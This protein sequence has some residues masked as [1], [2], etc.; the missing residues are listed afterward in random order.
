LRILLPVH[1]ID[2]GGIGTV[3]R[4]LLEHLPAALE[5]DEELVTLRRS[6]HGSPRVP[7]ANSLSRL[8]HEQVAVARAAQH[9][10][11]VHLPDHRPLLVS[12]TPFLLTVHDLFYVD[13]PDWLPRHVARY[14]RLMLRVALAKPPALVVCDSEY[15]RE[16]FCERF[17]EVAERVRVIRPGV[18]PRPPLNGAERGKPYFLTVST[19]EP[20]KNH[21]GLLRAFRLARERGLGLRWKVAGAAGYAAGP[22]LRALRAQEGVDV[23]G[24]VPPQQLERLFASARFLA[25]P[26]LGEGFGFPPLEAMA[27]GL[28]VICSSGTALDETVGAAALRVSP[29]DQIAWSD[30]LLELAG[31]DAGRARLAALGAARATR[32]SW[33]ASARAYARAYREVV[34][35]R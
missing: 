12:R 31:D 21:L 19:I 3:V 4:G 33:T 15:V 16:R 18:E 27:R 26:A 9:A 5:D 8:L 6:L 24:R 14:K 28:P 22:I 34:A 10:D 13:R 30:A 35:S 11:I 17:P 25:H 23:L 20:R 1:Q 2:E 7:L 29:S 32:F